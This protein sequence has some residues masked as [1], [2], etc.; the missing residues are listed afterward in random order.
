MVI[1]NPFTGA[2][3]PYTPPAPLT[4]PLGLPNVPHWDPESDGERLLLEDPDAPHEVGAIL[5]MNQH[6]VSGFDIAT[7]LGKGKMQ[8]VHEMRLDLDAQEDAGAQGRE[9]YND[10]VVV[11]SRCNGAMNKRMGGGFV[12]PED[13]VLNFQASPKVG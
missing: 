2:K 8:V 10:Q 1:P 7:R 9:I 3:K 5:R 4:Q 6:G 13:G 12:C 11:C